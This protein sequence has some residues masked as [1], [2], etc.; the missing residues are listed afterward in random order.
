MRFSPRSSAPETSNRV[1]SGIMPMIVPGRAGAVGRG[2]GPGGAPADSARGRTDEWTP[3]PCTGPAATPPRGGFAVP[4]APSAGG[5]AAGGG[6]GSPPERSGATVR[7]APAGAALALA[8][9]GT[10][11]DGG[12]AGAAALVATPGGSVFGRSGASHERSL[13][14]AVAVSASRRVACPVRAAE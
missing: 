1:P 3:G 8:A 5:L 2:T 12:I 7:N 9:P 4:K 10:A 13:A 14:D 6:T 11:G